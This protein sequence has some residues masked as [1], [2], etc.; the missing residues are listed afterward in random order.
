MRCSIGLVLLGGEQGGRL[1]PRPQSLHSSEGV[2]HS[3]RSD[4]V[5]CYDRLLAAQ[6]IFHSDVVHRFPRHLATELVLDD[7][8]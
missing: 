4:K 1:F 5:G 7:V 8:L 2:C 3:V 6:S